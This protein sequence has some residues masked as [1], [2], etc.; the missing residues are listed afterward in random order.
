MYRLFRLVHTGWAMAHLGILP[1]PGSDVGSAD[2]T[3]WLF[4]IRVYVLAELGYTQGFSHTY[5]MA[6]RG[7]TWGLFHV[8]VG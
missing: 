7:D 4:H 5:V 1:Y 6:G 8:N 3:H 2:L